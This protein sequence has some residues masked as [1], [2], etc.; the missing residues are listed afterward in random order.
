MV[1]ENFKAVVSVDK[2]NIFLLILLRKS[3]N[4]LPFAEIILATA[5]WSQDFLNLKWFFDFSNNEI[6]LQFIEISWISWTSFQPRILVF[7]NV[8]VGNGKFAFIQIRLEH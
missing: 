7:T 5:N 3:A 6:L 8:V 2:S 1:I 4:L